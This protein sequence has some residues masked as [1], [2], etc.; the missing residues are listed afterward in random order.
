M[1]GLRRTYSF[2]LNHPIGKKQP[3]YS[4]FKWFIWQLKTCVHRGPYLIPFIDDTKLAVSKGQTGAT[5]NI[6]VG[7]HEFNDMGFLLHFLKR[8]DVFFDIGANVGVYSIL[9]S[10]C[11]KAI[12]YSFEPVPSTFKAFLANITVNKLDNVIHA[13][14]IAVGS[15]DGT[16][17]FT[18]DQDTT[19]HAVLDSSIVENTIKVQVKALDDLKYPCPKLIKIDVEGFETEALS[20]AK[21]TLEN[22]DLK[23]IIIEL[24]GSGARYG[25]DESQIHNLLLEL[26][27]VCCNYDPF[28]RQL[29][30]MKTF[31]QYNTIYIRDINTIEQ[32]LKIAPKFQVS[33][34]EI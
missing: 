32:E 30:Q 27:F 24:N 31:G 10:G 6:Y 23:A 29:K 17:R 26:G 25:Y 2:I 4:F 11:C 13:Y 34:L 3:V 15:S 8:G 14:N 7:L 20:G 28:T 21:T 19:N 22:P 5:G 12:S 16:L 18:A 1:N 33:G 9:A